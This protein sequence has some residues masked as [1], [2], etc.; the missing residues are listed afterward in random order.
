MAEIIIHGLGIVRRKHPGCTCHTCKFYFCGQ[1]PAFQETDTN[2]N[3]HASTRKR[4]PSWTPVP[5]EMLAK[6]EK[7]TF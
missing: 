5:R 6:I 3:T 1:C 2:G 7:E 4:C